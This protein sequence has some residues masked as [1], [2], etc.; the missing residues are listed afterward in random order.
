MISKFIKN[1]CFLALRFVFVFSLLIAFLVNPIY[2][3]SIKTNAFKYVLFDDFEKNESTEIETS[4]ESEYKDYT[5]FFDSL[6]SLKFTSE[7][8]INY[9]GRQMCFLEFNP[10][11]HLPPPKI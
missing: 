11:I 7:F 3:V 5:Y 2:K 4:C 8:G 6:I 9:Y 1:I 10:K